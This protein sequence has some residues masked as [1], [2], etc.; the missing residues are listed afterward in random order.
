MQFLR[1]AARSSVEFVQNKY[2]Q[3][4]MAGGAM[5]STVT[6]AALPTDAAA[7]M[8]AL[9]GNVTDMLGAVWPI[10]I[11]SVGGFALIKLFKKGASKA[12]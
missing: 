10:V 8:T 5:V 7:A 9:S 3:V 11:L 4:V 2:G 6:H 12:I 1:K